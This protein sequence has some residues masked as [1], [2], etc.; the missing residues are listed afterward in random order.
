M[1]RIVRIPL[2]VAL[3]LL[4]QSFGAFARGPDDEAELAFAYGDQIR[5]LFNATIL[6]PS[7][8]PGTAIPNDLPQAG[9][10]FYLQ[11]SYSL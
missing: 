7:L 6:E 4:F 2:I 1:K 5:N 8:A 11:A 3:G 10:S 9:R